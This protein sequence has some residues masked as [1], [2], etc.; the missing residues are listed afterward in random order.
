MRMDERGKAKSKQ[1]LLPGDPLSGRG[2]MKTKKR[3]KDSNDGQCSA[4]KMKMQ[5]GSVNVS[6]NKR[7]YM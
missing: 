2:T 7:K 6:C 3:K 1:R 4:K 5:H